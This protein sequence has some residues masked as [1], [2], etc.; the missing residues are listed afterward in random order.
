MTYV[1]IAVTEE[2]KGW[3]ENYAKNNHIDLSAAIRAA[4]F[5][6]IENEYFLQAAREYEQEK[7]MDGHRSYTFEEAMKELG[8]EDE[9]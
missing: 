1:S 3:M 9:V 4:F 5:E 2:E 6:K 8:L 7:K